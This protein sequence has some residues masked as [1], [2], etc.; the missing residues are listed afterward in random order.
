MKRLDEIFRNIAFRKGYYAWAGW[1]LMPLGWLYGCIASLRRSWYES[2]RRR[3]RLPVP[4]ISVGNIEVGGT[5]KT[6]VTIWLARRIV[7]MGYSVA[8]VARNFGRRESACRVRLDNADVR[9][10]FTDEVL[11]I[12]ESLL[13][14]ARVYSGRYKYKAAVRAYREEKPDIIIIDDGFQHLK[15]FRDIEIVVLDFSSPFGEG[16]I[17]PAGTLREFPSCLSRANHIWINRIAPG[18]SAAWIK[19]RVSDYNWKATVQFSRVN[20]T[21]F[22]LASGKRLPD[23]PDVPVLAFCGIGRPDSFRNSLKE[24]GIRIE[25][26][27]VFPDHYVYSADDIDELRETMRNKGATALIT[28][29]KDAVKLNGIPDTDNILV[30]TMNLEVEGAIPEL[31]DDIQNT[32]HRYRKLRDRSDNTIDQ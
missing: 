8:V 29:E 4:I 3:I 16:G 14:K 25:G 13:G 10:E 15:L 24:A 17:L 23:I 21:G 31:L 12:A 30:Q 7:G 5:G 27:E 2:G 32:I 19:R 6:P 11:L 18:M 9:K 22:K 28:T 26:L 20:P 1:L